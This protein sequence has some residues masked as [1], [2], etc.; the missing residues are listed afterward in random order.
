MD[1]LIQSVCT[2]G[3]L[4]RHLDQPVHKD[5][6]HLRVHIYLGSSLLSAST[7]VQSRGVLHTAA[8]GTAEASADF[9]G[10]EV[11]TI[12]L[13]DTAFLVVET[14]SWDLDPASLDWPTS[15]PDS[16]GSTIVAALSLT[17]AVFSVSGCATIGKGGASDNGGPTERHGGATLFKGHPWPG[18]AQEEPQGQESPQR[19][20]P[21]SRR[22]AVLR[23]ARPF[24][25]HLPSRAASRLRDRAPAPGPPRGGGG[26]GCSSGPEA[27]RCRC[28]SRGEEKMD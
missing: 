7:S 6:A 1:S 18:G 3:V 25:S 28:S 27:G 15:R 2:E 9:R 26:G 5:S 22:R 21:A 23:C 17:A 11:G 20:L 14:T 16:G 4:L 8:G 19:R 10:L 24:S 12:S 13:T